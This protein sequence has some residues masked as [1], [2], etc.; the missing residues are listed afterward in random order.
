MPACRAH[1]PSRPDRRQQ[2]HKTTDKPNYALADFIA[3]P[4]TDDFIGGFVVGIHGADELNDLW[5]VVNGIGRQLPPGVNLPEGVRQVPAE[6]VVLWE[7][8]GTRNLQV[9]GAAERPR[10]YAA[11]VEHLLRLQAATAEVRDLLCGGVSTEKSSVLRNGRSCP[12]A[13]PSAGRLTGRS[14]RDQLTVQVPFD[15]SSASRS[16]GPLRSLA[17]I[18]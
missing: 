7:D 9:L 10:A 18:T 1:C 5:R 6:R 11:V 2:I 3:P 17:A 4:G 16:P 12:W 13:D 14:G 15:R 8:V